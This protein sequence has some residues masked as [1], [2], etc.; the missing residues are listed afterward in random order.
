MTDQEL[1]KNIET[2]MKQQVKELK[3]IYNRG[4]E[5]Q[6]TFTTKQLKNLDPDKLTMGQVLSLAN[7]IDLQKQINE[8]QSAIN[9]YETIL[10]K[11]DNKQTTTK[12]L[13][14]FVEEKIVFNTNVL[15]LDIK[16]YV[17]EPDNKF[18]Q[19]FLNLD[20]INDTIS[21]LNN[22]VQIKRT[23]EKIVENN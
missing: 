22:Y 11:I 18:N 15:K 8:Y 5:A 19:E 20:T 1:V 17:T 10:Q 12:D 6:K 16:E 21:Q 2:R 14:A 9:A 7:T 23:I 13:L 3:T 4:L